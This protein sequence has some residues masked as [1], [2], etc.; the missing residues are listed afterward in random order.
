M[1][2]GAALPKLAATKAYGAE[3][4]LVGETIDESL[5]AARAFAEETGATLIHPFDHRDIVAGQATVR[6]LGKFA[7]VQA[8]LDGD[9]QADFTIAVRESTPVEA[10]DFIL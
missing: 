1:P 4:V 9:G 5:V 2:V 6:D 7:L 10:S 8:D 3:V